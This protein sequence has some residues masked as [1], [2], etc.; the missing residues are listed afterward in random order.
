ML[1][2]SLTEVV[3]QLERYH[4][5]GYTHHGKWNLAQI[6]EHLSDWLEYMLDGY[7]PT[8][9]PISWLFWCVRHTLG[10]RL[11]RQTLAAGKMRAGAPTLPQTVHSAGDLD[12][13]ASLERLRRVVERFENHR[14]SFRP[15]PLFG[16]FTD[17]QARQLQLIHCSHH[18]QF[19]SPPAAT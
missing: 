18:L 14:G 6:A 12:E 10:G 7:P 11:L 17:E 19:L 2:R 15:S 4:Q 8:K 16:P 1:Y 13:A 3:Q 5:Q 9:P